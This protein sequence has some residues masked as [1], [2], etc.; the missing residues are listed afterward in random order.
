MRLERYIKDMLIELHTI[1]EMVDTHGAAGG[2]RVP[3]SLIDTRRQAKTLGLKVVPQIEAANEVGTVAQQIQKRR[4]AL[5]K[6]IDKAE[7]CTTIRSPRPSCSRP[8]APTRWPIVRAS[9]D[10]LELIVPDDHWPLP[11]YREMLFPV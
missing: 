5:G 11:K 2:V 7:A 1:R 8:K 6:V 9:C 3:G 4:A 10:A